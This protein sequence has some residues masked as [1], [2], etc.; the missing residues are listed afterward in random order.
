M[1]S[2]IQIVGLCCSRRRGTVPMKSLARVAFAVLLALAPRGLPAQGS[3]ATGTSVGVAGYSTA[4]QPIALMKPT[5]SA[6]L[7][8]KAMYTVTVPGT[9]AWVDAGFAVTPADHM[10]VSATGTVVLAD[11]R[12]TGPVGVAHGWKD[13]LR[14][15]PAE[16]AN[17]GA[18]VARIGDTEAAVPF[19]LG[20]SVSKDAPA[21]GELYLA[22]NAGQQ[23]AG[24][25]SFTAVIK[26]TK[27][28]VVTTAAASVDLAQAITPALLASIPRR[29]ADAQGDA[30]DVVNFSILGT[31]DQV[32]K[33][34]AAAG[35]VQ[36][37]KTN[38]QA[39]LHGL[40]ST[41]SKQAY[42]EMPMSTLY[43]YGRPQD[44]SYARADPLMVA[45]ERHH[46]RVW[47]SGQTVAGRPLWVGS[48][49][50]DNG[51]ERD[52]RNNGVTHHIDPQIDVERDFIEQSFAAAGAL[53]A[54]AYATP[55]NPIRAASTATGGS[56]QSDGR[57]LLMALGSH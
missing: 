54:A 10:D 57:L 45:V 33:A 13:L 28:T 26:L 53:D 18:L 23:L 8:R 32:K 48:A 17:T 25:G 24:T 51:L 6:L 43:L 56:F 30:G 46:L 35:W 15:F 34:F 9:G 29:V 11:S 49:T 5:A 50:H 20:A 55:A 47:Q 3:V 41:L 2:S 40:I 37:D 19:A 27:A 31:E 36:V 21:T 42:L 7:A 44:L 1:E 38:N 14:G 22:V 16:G 12:S 4:V 52:E 39:V